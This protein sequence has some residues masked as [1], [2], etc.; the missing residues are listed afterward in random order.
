AIEQRR[1]E[2]DLA[3]ESFEI[4]L[5]PDRIARDDPVAPAVEAG[6]EAEGNVQIERQRTRD[7]LGVAAPGVLAELL[8]A[9]RLVELR[10]R[11]IGRVARPGPVVATQQLGMK[12]GTAFMICTVEVHP[13]ARTDLGQLPGSSGS[14]GARAP[15][16][17]SSYCPESTAQKNA[18]T[19]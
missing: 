3:Q 19:A 14:S 16:S 10:R 8:F 2:L 7:G 4:A 6:A 12:G 18:A 11:R 5:A 1:H 15:S 9:E 13:A 17:R